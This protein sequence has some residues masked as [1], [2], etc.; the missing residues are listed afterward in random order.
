VDAYLHGMLRK[1][2]LSG[3]RRASHRLELAVSEY[4]S[5]ATA[6]CLPHPERRLEVAHQLA[7]VCRDAC[8]RKESSKTGSVLSSGPCAPI[9]RSTSAMGTS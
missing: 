6:L 8:A 7:A 9:S 3:R 2:R 5:L 4:D 1:L